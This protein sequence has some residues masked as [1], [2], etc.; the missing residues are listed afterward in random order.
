MAA[1]LSFQ[2]PLVSDSA[3]VSICFSSFPRSSLTSNARLVLSPQRAVWSMLTSV[4]G[5]R[6]FLLSH[7]QWALVTTTLSQCLQIHHPLAA[8]FMTYWLLVATLMNCGVYANVCQRHLMRHFMFERHLVFLLLRLHGTEK[9]VA[10]G[11]VTRH[12]SERSSLH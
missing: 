4:Q 10:K 7:L 12:A 6:R 1:F 5:L 11:K 8:K 3:D 9:R 2:V